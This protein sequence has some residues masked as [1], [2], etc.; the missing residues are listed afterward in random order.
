MR[1]WLYQRRRK[2]CS[3]GGASMTRESP[4][5]AS[6]RQWPQRNFSLC[7]LLIS[8]LQLSKEKYE[9]AWRK[10]NAAADNKQRKLLMALPSRIKRKRMRRKE[11]KEKE[12]RALQPLYKASERVGTL[13]PGGKA[14]GWHLKVGWNARSVKRGAVSAAAALGNNTVE[15]LLS[16]MCL[17]ISTSLNVWFGRL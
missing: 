1:T 3:L 11:R 5:T 12:G 13:M 17:S 2:P 9:S 16:S 14:N 8:K 6:Y 4:S 15:K 7:C 10:C